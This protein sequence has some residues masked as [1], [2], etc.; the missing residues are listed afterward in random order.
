MGG[1]RSYQCIYY[2]GQ[3]L[4]LRVTWFAQHS[5]QGKTLTCSHGMPQHDACF[6]SVCKVLKKK[7]IRKEMLWQYTDVVL[8]VKCSLFQW[9][10]V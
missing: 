2:L 5:A 8:L 7:Q 4:S 1:F 9:S 10:V 6:M 3:S